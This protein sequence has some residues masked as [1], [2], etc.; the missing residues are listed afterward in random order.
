MY[1]DNSQ[2]IENEVL[3]LYVL[4]KFDVSIT[5]K[6]L[7]EILLSPGLINYFG[8]QTG[9]GKLLDEKL[10]IAYTDTD[11]VN[12][13][14]LSEDGKR[15]LDTLIP[16]VSPA[17]KN[18]YDAYLAKEKNKIA[19]ETNINAYPFIDSNKNQCI[20][21]YIRE[22]GNKVV[23]IRIPVPDRETALQM[24]ANWKTN[25]YGIL[26]QIMTDLNG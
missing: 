26:M 2:Q 14:G 4:S 17:V 16:T 11:G 8:F 6:S 18:T 5:E 22:N 19:M 23:D 20:R 21:C 9:L 13:Y 1:E 3:I 25:A 24:C 7:T 10:I 12:M 15:L